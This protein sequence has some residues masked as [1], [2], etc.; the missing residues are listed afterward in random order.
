MKRAERRSVRIDRPMLS[1]TPEGR[2]RVSARV[3]GRA[4]GYESDARLSPSAEAYL[5]A[6][7]LPAMAR[8]LDLEIDAEVDA[9]WLSRVEQVRRFVRATWTDYDGGEVR[10]SG[11]THLEPAERAVRAQFFGGGVDSLHL[12]HEL[13]TE[14]GALVFAGGFDVPLTD[15]DRLAAVR[16][17]NGRIADRCGLRLLDVSTDLRSHPL[18]RRP[19]WLML[20]GGALASVGHLLQRHVRSCVV[21]GWGRITPPLVHGSHPEIEPG[22]SSGAVAFAFRG[23]DLSRVEKVARIA[24][25][26]V[27]REHLRVC[28]EH[29]SPALNCGQCEK[30][31]RTRLELL[32]AGAL[33][34]AST[35]PPGDLAD[36]IDRIEGVTMPVIPFYR[37]LLQRI[38]DRRVC[39]SLERLLERGPPRR[40]RMRRLT[41]RLHRILGNV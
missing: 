1:R 24:D 7:L 10:A 31:V 2:Y 18:Y 25:W 6:F 33:A 15:P 27:F 36:A 9:T 23:G 39:A 28:W 30:C 11:M 4:V 14:L 8:G 3:D 5:T 41:R 21:S 29:R 16:Q 26:S 22:W 38:D 17:Q 19:S 32:A 34:G 13:R 12:L 40:S 37:D 35:F 20:Y